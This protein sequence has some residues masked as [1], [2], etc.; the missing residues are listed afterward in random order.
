M[1]TSALTGKEGWP[2]P[3]RMGN[4]GPGLSRAMRDIRGSQDMPEVRQ[5]YTQSGNYR[6]M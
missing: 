3:E 4:L 6:N 2:Q 1:A 5:I